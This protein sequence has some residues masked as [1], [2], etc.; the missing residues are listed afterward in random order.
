[1]LNAQRD[2]FLK[3]IIALGGS[4]PSKS[5]MMPPYGQTLTLDEIRSL[6]AFARAIAVPPY[7]L[8]ARAGLQILGEMQSA[9]FGACS[10]SDLRGR[11]FQRNFTLW[12]DFPR[13]RQGPHA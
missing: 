6:I 10:S 3:S 8:P 13:K 2:D 9:R 5:A 1:V 11:G 4:A 7:Q 12:T